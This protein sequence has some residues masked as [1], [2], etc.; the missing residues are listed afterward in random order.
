MNLLLT[1]GTGFFGLSLI[2]YWQTLANEAPLVSILSRNPDEFQRKYPF[3]ASSVKWI[4]G[5][6]LD[7][8]TLPRSTPF[9][10]IIHAAADSTFGPRL[11]LMERHD[12]IVEGTKN[13]LRL[14][15]EVGAKRFLFTSSG[16]IYGEQPI[17]LGKI[18]ETYLGSPDPLDPKNTYSTSKRAA[19]HLC[20]LYHQKYGLET[21][22]ARC[23]SF[24]GRDL[25]LDAHFALG[26][27][28]RDALFREQI[29]VCSDGS[30]SRSYLDQEDLAHWL[31]VLL[32]RGTAGEA[33]NVGSD[34]SI[35][36]RALAHL[37]SDIIAPRKPVIIKGQQGKNRER[38]N[39]IP[40]IS[41]AKKEL[42]LSI[43]IQLADAIKK[44]ANVMEK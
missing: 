19:E 13:M 37:V 14:A 6:I 10:H 40:N 18:P 25:P 39:Y 35:T 28:I 31:M 1:G 33:Y 27:F 16:S 38:L 12:Q 34:Q 11:D 3:L 22:I 30:A 7:E 29:I 2:R 21:I 44:S 26:N 32:E 20:C 8:S 24:S 43:T 9:S 42:G 41:K 36:T 23:F 17:H 15:Q 4:Q 5:D